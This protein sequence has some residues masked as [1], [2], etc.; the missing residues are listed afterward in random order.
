MN[1]ILNTIRKRKVVDTYPI[2]A[3]PTIP[4]DCTKCE[5]LGNSVYMGTLWELYYHPDTNPTLE[6]Y[7]ARMGKDE[8]Y[9][10]GI[11]GIL[12]HPMLALAFTRKLVGSLT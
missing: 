8:K 2:T 5:Y 1:K 11:D 10:S 4:H 9:V 7:I 12:R 6:T 3:L